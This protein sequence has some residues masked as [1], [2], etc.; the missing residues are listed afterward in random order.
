M[1]SATAPE[2]MV[3]GGRREHGLEDEI[4]PIRICAVG[5]GDGVAIHP[6]V[7]SEACKPKDSLE[8]KVA[9]IHEVESDDCVGQQ[10]DGDDGDVLEK[11]VD[12][13]LRL[14]QPG[15]QTRKA[16]VHDE[17]EERGDEHPRVVDREHLKR[18]HARLFLL[19]EGD[20]RRQHEEED[21]EHGTAGDRVTQPILHSVLLI[22][23]LLKGRNP[24]LT[25]PDT[26]GLA[27]VADEDL[28]VADLACAGGLG[29]CGDHRVD[30]RIVGHNLD[31]DLGHEV[32]RILGTSID[33]GV[34]PSVDQTL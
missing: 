8:G 7:Q 17:H 3:G 31:L 34:S 6:R 5:V 14:C 22:L 30:L 12:G 10:A 25:S 24:S 33:L 15:L 1:R 11:D 16:E 4:G 27:H 21:S 20:L 2:T 19:S 23:W 9:R 28:A 32:D 18:H 29:D 13:V 26:D